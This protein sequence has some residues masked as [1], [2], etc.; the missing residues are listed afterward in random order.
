[1]NSL[2]RL[3]SDHYHPLTV[4]LAFGA[5]G[6]F[7]GNL[8]NG[9]NPRET[10]RLLAH[11]AM[12]AALVPNCLAL[13]RSDS[14]QV[15]KLMAITGTKTYLQRDA[16]MQSGWATIPGSEIASYDL[17]AACLNLLDFAPTNHLMNDS[18]DAY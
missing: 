13:S 15:N 16:M 14:D 2:K 7:V 10:E 6:F 17:A 18:F 4:A 12:I 3:Y 9:P 1:M 5:A 11:D 8:Q